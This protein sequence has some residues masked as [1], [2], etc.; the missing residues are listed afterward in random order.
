MGND[1]S[2]SNKTRQDEAI[3]WKN[4]GNEQFQQGNYLEA[5][6]CYEKGIEFDPENSVL[7]NN[8]GVSLYKL[9][10]KEEAK[11]C[12]EKAKELEQRNQQQKPTTIP[13][14]S[15]ISDEF[16]QVPPKNEPVTERKISEENG[17]ILSEIPESDEREYCRNCGEELP[18]RQGEWPPSLPK[19]CPSCGVRIKDPIRYGSRNGQGRTHIEKLKNPI[20]AA[21]LSIIPGLGHA[22]NGK[23][24]RG[25]LFFFGTIVGLFIFVFPG[26]IVWIIGIYDAFSIAKKM[27]IGDIPFRKT[28]VLKMVGYILLLFIFSG[29]IVAG[30]S[31]A[32]NPEKIGS[33]P[34]MG[35]A[36]K[37]ATLEKIVREYHQTHTYT[38]EDL[39]VCGDMSS[40]VW[41]MV[42][43][44][45]IDAMI[46]VGNVEKDIT[47][48]EDANHV[49]VIAEIEPDE[50]IALETTGGFLVCADSKICP[51][52]NPRYYTG[53]KFSSPK[54]LKDALEK[55]KHPCPD[56]YLYGSDKLCHPACGGDKYCTGNS[57]C[58]NGRCVACQEGY[59]LGDDY[60]CHEQCGA[61]GHY[62]TG[63]SFCINGQCMKCPEGQILGTDLKCHQPCGSTTSYCTG[64]S[65]CINGQCRGCGEGY[66]L[67][68][69]LRCYPE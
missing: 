4:K 15:S 68:T 24:G 26:V 43:T 29:I 56:G 19:L 53:W 69:D 55:L 3:L 50:W 21:L 5:L 67:G 44:Q 62:C 9:G 51:I 1:F 35:R 66:Y 27:N 36:S 48:I 49:W 16:S 34:F 31:Y 63:D 54:E 17:K 22:Y 65:I 57:V 60:Q 11:K 30:Y 20:L 14:D 32:T 38:L 6:S 42:E 10:K 37:I 47:S 45:N 23:V 28:S 64:D 59:I 61:E 7:W 18:Y 46:V 12:K 8:I 41:N 2:R 39:Y 58:L 40:D 33:L 52:N 13:A 25:L